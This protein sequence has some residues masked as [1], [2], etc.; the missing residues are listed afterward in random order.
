MQDL[1][2]LIDPSSGWQ[3]LNAE[4]IND[5]GVIVGWGTDPS[6]YYEAFELTPI[7]EPATLGLLALGGVAMLRRRR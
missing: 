7:P 6:G 4:D 1:N 5:S 2:S 3:L